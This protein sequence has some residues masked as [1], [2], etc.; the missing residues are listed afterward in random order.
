MKI[1]MKNSF[2]AF[3]LRWSRTR[4]RGA[5]AVV[6][7]LCLTLVMAA[8]AVSFDT[9]NLALQRQSL[10]NLTDAA[11]QA[12][13]V[14]L[15]DDTKNLIGAQKAAFDYAYSYDKSFTLADVTL[16]CIVPSNGDAVHPDVAPGNI[17]AVCDPLVY[18]GKKC[19]ESLCSFPIT[20]PSSATANA[21]RIKHTGTVDFYF[22]PA[23]GIK[24]GS[25]GAVASVSCAKSCGSG[26]IPNPL[27]IAIVADRTPSMSDQDF[28]AMKNGIAA[29]LATMTPEYQFVT[30]GTINRSQ[31]SPTDAECLTSQG[32]PVALVSGKAPSTY[33]VGGARAG[34]WMPLGFSNSYLTGTLGDAVGTRTLIQTKNKN[35]LG[36]EVQCMDH[37][38]TA[39]LMVS[40]TSVS[41][42]P[43]GT[44]LAAP[45]KAAAQ[46]LLFPNNSN[47]AT[48]T[49]GRKV[50]T[51][52]PTKKWVIFETDGQPDETMG[53]NANASTDGHGNVTSPGYKDTNTS[54]GS[55]DVLTV[56][57]EPTA[58]TP[59]ND[60]LGCQN[61]VDVATSAKKAGNDVNIIMIAYGAATTATCG[62]VNNKNIYVK[63]QMAA[64]ASPVN[65]S[66]SLADK[67]CTSVNGQPAAENADGDY[68]FCASTAA[69][70]QNIFKTAIGMASSP[71]TKFVR[72]PK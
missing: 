29:G 34:K 67:S 17:P 42:F 18:T 40:G 63:D 41:K 20:L 9:A 35:N 22:A 64:A 1:T 45:L 24:N 66:P 14:Y 19:N 51:S 52:A 36:Y 5:T 60:V 37:V 27:D 43:W 30:L 46:T 59:S 44:S 53:Y 8:A 25:T 3:R 71:N 47:L 21:I 33:P 72:M 12:G 48:L 57:Q 4:E 31:A 62:K 13:A 23:I 39:N 68:F 26:G 55:T 38:S 7:A 58:L 28:D 16:W 65:G 15:R 54:A 69:D 10:Q 61:L 6:I 56:G 70:L 2:E 11:A 49:T 50:L 32:A